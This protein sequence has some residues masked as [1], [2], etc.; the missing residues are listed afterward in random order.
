L[1]IKIWPMG[2]TKCNGAK[3]LTDES[4]IGPLPEWLD[5]V[6]YRFSVT[7]VLKW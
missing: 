2:M 1:K 5:L 7:W 6:V 3:L 4:R